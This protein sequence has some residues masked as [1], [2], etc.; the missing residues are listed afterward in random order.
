LTNISSSSIHIDQD[1]EEQSRV[2][3]E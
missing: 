2:Q 1:R 3:R